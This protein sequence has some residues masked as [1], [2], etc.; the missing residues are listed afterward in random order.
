MITLK[1]IL[2]NVSFTALQLQAKKI[3]ILK[4]LRNNNNFYPLLLI[5]KQHALYLEHVVKLYV[6]LKMVK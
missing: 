3:V 5:C 2:K 4:C 6:K 1:D